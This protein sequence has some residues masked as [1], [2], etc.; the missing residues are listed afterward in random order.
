VFSVKVVPTLVIVTL[1]RRISTVIL[2]V[3][4]NLNWPDFLLQAANSDISGKNSVR[5]RKSKEV[6]RRTL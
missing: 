2:R 6:F 3:S 4:R 1:Q 5:I